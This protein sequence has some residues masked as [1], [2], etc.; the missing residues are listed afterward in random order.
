MLRISCLLIVSLLTISGT[1]QAQQGACDFSDVLMLVDRS[2][3]MRG[4]ID[5]QTKWDITRDAVSTVLE[6][7][8]EQANF[9]L[10]IYPG[11]SGL[12]AAGVEGPVGACRENMAE[13]MCTPQAPHC[14]TGEV[15]V[16]P[17]QGTQAA[18]NE[19]MVWPEGLHDSYTPT[20]QSLEAAGNYAPLLD[21][22]S[23]S[24][25]ILVTDGYQCC[26]L[27]RQ[28]DGFACEQE[29]RNL[30]VEKVRRLA[31]LDIV[32]FVVGFGGSVD[33]D[34][35]QRA[36][37]AAGTQRENCDP[38]ANM[39]G[40][41][42]CYYQADNAQSLVDAMGDVARR[43]RQ[44]V[45]DGFDNDCDGTVD[46]NTQMNAC[47]QCGAAAMEV[48]N[49]VDDDCDGRIDEGTNLNACGQCDV[50]TP[51]EVCDGADNDCDGTIDEGVA[52]ACGRCGVVPEE[53]CNGL[54][55]DCD[56]RTDEGVQ[57]ACG[58]CGDTPTEA[59]NRLDD[60][61][62]GQIDEGYPPNCE[63]CP[64][65]TD[66]TC[67][68]LDD[69]C[70][71]EIDEGLRNE[72]GT[73]GA[74]PVEICNGFDDDCDSR[75]D[76]GDGLCPPN[77]ACLCGGCVGPCNMNECPGGSV[78]IRGFCI[79]DNCPQ[80]QHCQ[81]DQCVEG[82]PDMG[83]Q[84]MPRDAGT[85]RFDAAPGIAGAPAED[86]GCAFSQGVG[87]SAWW[88]MGLVLLNPGIR[89]WRTHVSRR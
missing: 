4:Q 56:L 74:G 17:A 57:N 36:A 8:G 73:C 25:V 66:E 40:G 20:W 61:C 45:C 31:E 26:G 30:V 2:I 46:E 51:I 50:P 33:V 58:A 14:S 82:E 47:A 21:G 55:D 65:P 37:V 69:D 11:P 43:I 18:I 35:L 16:A 10:M 71:G 39:N 68:D 81:G 63:Q 84:P 19:A 29:D 48:C 44:E 64:N 49:M 83:L 60:D 78:C 12:G 79:Q 80:G 54:D 53:A 59:C 22:I 52:N 38:Q 6:N 1:A 62:D 87:S 88:L 41:N 24:F 9:G 3:S 42:L 76:E 13:A 72:C 67:N 15:V 32:T 7:Y 77:E 23:R 70:D 34:T 5:G 86:C 27:F 28:G 85:P 75:P 89:R